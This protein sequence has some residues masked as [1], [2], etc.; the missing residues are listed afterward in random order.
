LPDAAELRPLHVAVDGGVVAGAEAGS[1][2]PILLLHGLGGTWGYWQRTLELLAGRARPIAL[3][4][5]GFGESDAPPLGFALYSASDRLAAALAALGGSPAVVCGHSMGGP[6]ALRL[7]VRHPDAVTRLVLVGPSGFA[8]SPAWQRRLFRALPLY[9]LLQRA[10]F[11]W[12]R[13]LVG[14]APLRRVVLTALVDS[15][16]NLDPHVV[17]R[18][19]EGVR[20]ARELSA[21]ATAS[22]A[23]GFEQ[24]ARLV[25]VPIAAIWGD[26]DR[27]VPPS[28]AAELRRTVPSAAIHILPACGHMPMIERP[29][30]FAALLAKLALE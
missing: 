20:S 26:R 30:A 27:I 8:P 18:L 1:G 21:G 16:A 12:E 22:L 4:L 15:P 11:A 19:L 14:L 10:P 24:E 6:L 2:T 17:A 25:Q 5:P 23:T 29:E 7:A 28:D 3:D 13:R 9:G